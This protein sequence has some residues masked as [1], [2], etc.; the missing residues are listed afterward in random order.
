MRKLKEW[1]KETFIGKAKTAHASEEMKGIC[2]LLPNGSQL[3][4]CFEESKAHHTLLGNT[5]DHFLWLLLQSM[6]PHCVVHPFGQLR[7]AVLVLSSPSSSFPPSSLLAEQ[8]VRRWKFLGSVQT[9]LYN[10]KNSLCHQ[11]CFHHISKT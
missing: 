9:L 4:S 2:S 6:M 3:L 11:H 1:D 7:S 10:N 5:N 8:S